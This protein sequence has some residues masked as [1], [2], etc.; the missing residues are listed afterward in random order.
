MQ[1]VDV[2]CRRAVDECKGVTGTW[3]TENLLGLDTLSSVIVHG[4]SL[5]ELAEER[6]GSETEGSRP[7]H[8]KLAGKVGEAAHVPDAE[9]HHY[10]SH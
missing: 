3:R 7:I 1:A 9:Q 10:C 4:M 2:Q 8:I 6:T 5:H